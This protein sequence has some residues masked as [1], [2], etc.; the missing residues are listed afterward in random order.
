M[1]IAIVTQAYYPILGGVTEHVWHLG[2]ELQRRGHQVTVITGSARDDDNHGL[3][4]LRHGFQIPVMSNGANV[5]LT[6]GW[7]LGRL[8]QR[9]E[10]A[11][12][13]DLVHIQAPLD[14]G[15]PLIASKAMRTPKV[16]T[17]HT[18]RQAS[19]GWL[20]RIPAIFRSVFLD[21][22]GKINHHIAVS[23]A[24]EE[25]VHR[26]FPAVDLTII[27]NGVDVERFS[28]S[29]PAVA[30]YRDGRLTIL[31]VGRMDPR[32]GAK[33]LFAALPYIERRLKNY[34]VLVVGTGW[35]QKYYDALIP[36]HLRRRVE[37]AGYI[38][39]EELPRYYRSADIYCSPATGNESFG[40]VLL[41]AMASGVPIVASDIDGYRWVVEPGQEG[42]LVPPRSP[43]HLANA[44]VELADN[45]RQRRQ[46]GELGRAKAMQYAWPK[47]VDRIEAVYRQILHP[48]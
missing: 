2:H 30:K 41:E 38:S 5:Y 3:R 33:F 27:P 48:A 8:L 46:M 28:P 1:R 37:F 26:Y 35:M 22:V 24:A 31:F 25:F 9:I 39:P 45:D 7:K 18:A 17:Y 12:R 44:I 20:E 40:I 47:V 11:E 29:V 21:A 23:P 34:R 4:V 15:L 6:V 32:K 43:P 19:G 36:H 10:Q 16:G 42:L 14:P 13:F